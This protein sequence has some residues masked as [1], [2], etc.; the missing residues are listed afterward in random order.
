MINNKVQMRN[1]SHTMILNDLCIQITTL[2]LLLYYYN[3]MLYHSTRKGNVTRGAAI[4]T[5]VVNPFC[6]AFAC[7]S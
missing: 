1:I 2:V 3:I 7:L 6:I 4:V 5:V